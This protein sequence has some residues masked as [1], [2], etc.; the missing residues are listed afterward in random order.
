M[1]VQFKFLFVFHSRLCKKFFTVA[2]SQSVAFTV[3]ISI[4]IG[5]TTL[6]GFGK[7]TVTL[8]SV[9]WPSWIKPY[10]QLRTVGMQNTN[11]PQYFVFF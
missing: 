1:W 9:M 6:F 3:L 2:K 7:V 11:A 5:N 8:L 4:C 10:K